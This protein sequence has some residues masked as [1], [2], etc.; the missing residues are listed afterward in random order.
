MRREQKELRGK[1]GEVARQFQCTVTVARQPY[2]GGRPCHQL[3]EILVRSGFGLRVEGHG[4]SKSGRSTIEIG[5]CCPYRS[6]RGGGVETERTGTTENVNLLR[7]PEHRLKAEP[8]VTDFISPLRRE[9]RS[10]HELS[11]CLR[12]R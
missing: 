7:Y 6:T 1:L 10:E 5:Q 11:T 12:D 8:K 9:V 2:D 3:F 4:E